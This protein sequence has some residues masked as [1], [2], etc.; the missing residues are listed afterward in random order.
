MFILGNELVCHRSIF[1]PVSCWIY[2]TAPSCRCVCLIFHYEACRLL[3]LRPVNRS[4]WFEMAVMWGIGRIPG[5]R[6]HAG[7][8]AELDTLIWK[9]PGEGLQDN[10]CFIQ[11]RDSRALESSWL[12][13]RTCT[14]LFLQVG[15][16]GLAPIKSFF[17]R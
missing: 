6:E 1:Q 5:M 15:V 14:C 10:S 9:A 4:C 16:P 17:E 3:R 8:A 13:W 12:G 2:F 11:L 7:E